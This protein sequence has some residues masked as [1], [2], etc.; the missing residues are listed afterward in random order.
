MKKIILLAGHNGAGTGANGILDEGKE[1]IILRDLI[2]SK[3]AGVPYIIEANTTLLPAVIAQMRANVQAG[4]ILCD[5][6]FNAAGSPGAQGTEIVVADKA[7]GQELALAGDLLSAICNILGTK[8]RGIIR[9]AQTARKRIA[10]LRDINCVNVLIEV[11]FV[12][13]PVDVMLYPAKR[14]AVAIAIAQILKQHLTL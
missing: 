13:S 8:R 14:E 5:I 4:D 9:E 6:H 3:L 2:A 1:T 11:C 10:V 7:T 12:T